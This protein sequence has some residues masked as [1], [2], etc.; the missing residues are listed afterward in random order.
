MTYEG[1]GVQIFAYF[2]LSMLDWGRAASH[3][4]YAR[5]LLAGGASSI[6]YEA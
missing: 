1:S 4:Q 5:R 3:V 6:D 2:S